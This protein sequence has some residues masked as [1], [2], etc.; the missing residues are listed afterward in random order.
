MLEAFAKD[1]SLESYLLIRR[2]F[3][4][5]KI[6]VA[7]FGGF[8]PFLAMRAE[9]EGQGIEPMLILGVMDGDERDIDELTLRM[10][11]WLVTRAKLSKAGGVQL[12]GSKQV[13]SD[14][15]IDYLLV[16]ILE[17]CERHSISLPSALVVLLREKLGGPNPY[18][19]A[20]YEISE[21][22]KEAVWIAAQIFGADEA[23]SIR[24]LAKELNIEPSTI[25]RWFKKGELEAEAHRVRD[26][27]ERHKNGTLF[28]D[29]FE[30][31]N[32]KKKIR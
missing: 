2:S 18:R 1:G 12:Q 26:M 28:Q 13:V 30:L 22:Q 32:S 29:L 20:R 31:T 15:L 7:R 10:M 27:L 25:S 6:E 24:R 21:K 9:L 3:P 14:S 11:E 4:N 17:S 16:I 5:Q 19:H 23:I 8:D